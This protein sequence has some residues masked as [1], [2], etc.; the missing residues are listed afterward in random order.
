M[1]NEQH[2]GIIEV[3]NAKP[4]TND[5]GSEITLYSFTME[6][7]KRWFRTGTKAMAF[8]K[9]DAIQFV[10]DGQKVDLNSMVAVQAEDVVRA[11]APA[12]GSRPATTAS[13]GASRT[14]S[15]DE[16]WANKEAKDVKKEEDYQNVAVPRMT[17]ST[18][19]QSAAAVVDAAL[20]T[21]ALSFGNVAKSKRIPLLSGFVQELA[22]EFYSYIM[23]GPTTTASEDTEDDE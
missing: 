19:I 11:P 23:D 18:A 17:R 14:V 7:S 9:G 21:D 8:G 6:G 10:A 22:E 2:K 15:R 1:A 12:V 16:Y 13:A 5:D 4:W 20:K 3:T